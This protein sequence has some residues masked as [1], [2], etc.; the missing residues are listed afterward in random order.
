MNWMNSYRDTVTCGP[1]D[2][3]VTLLIIGPNNVS[4]LVM[5]QWGNGDSSSFPAGIDA[6][7]ERKY[8]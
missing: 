7:F 2:F 3:R 5:M 4:S 6:F 1:D 8:F